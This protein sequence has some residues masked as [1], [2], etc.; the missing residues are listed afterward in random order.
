MTGRRGGTRAGRFGPLPIA[1]AAAVVAVLVVGALGF[2]LL[3]GPVPGLGLVGRSAARGD[4]PDRTPDAIRPYQPAGVVVPTVK[5][6]ILFV[7]A[8]RVWSVSGADRLT[9]I[10]TSAHAQSPVWSPDGRTIYFLDIH[11]QRASIPCS[12]IP[13]SGCTSATVPYT[14]QYPVLSRMP[15]SGG[16]PRPIASGLYSWAGGAYSYFWGLWQP[17]LSPNGRTF[18]LVSDAPNPLAA[19]DAIETMPVSGGSP[20]RLN[21]PEDPGLGQNDP[22]WS[23][24]G[25]T[26]AYTYNHMEGSVGRP[27]I[28]LYDVR[29]GAVRYLTG[30]GYAQPSY[31]PDGRYVAAVRTSTKGRDVVILDARTGA[32]LLRVT[33][34]GHGFAPVWSPAGDQIAFLHVNGLSIDLWVATLGGSGRAFSVT[35]T[36][37]LTS[38]SALDGASRPAWFIPVTELARPTPPSPSSA[39]TPSAAAAG[40][41]AAPDGAS[42]PP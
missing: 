24:D 40:G 4:V 28:G 14:L 12:M 37:P 19:D 35:G 1:Q 27:R 6:T 22:A 29:T 2:G 38:Q 42:G 33:S 16:T 17:A 11:S 41:T 39:A 20:S 26:I 9:Q 18:A 32:E 3:G 31:S 7:K 15:S 8:G 23:P 21:L 13:A 25:T 36:E 10:G 5:G 34:D 30:F